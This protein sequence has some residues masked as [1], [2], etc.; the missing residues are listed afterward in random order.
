MSATVNE[1]SIRYFI[2]YVLANFSWY[3]YSILAQVLFYFHIALN[4]LVRTS[5]NILD[6]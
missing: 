3:I 6:I 4:A 2:D 1:N 5:W